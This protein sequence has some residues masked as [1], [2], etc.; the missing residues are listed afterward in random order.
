MSHADTPRP[1]SSAQHD[2]P[3][4]TPAQPLH[5]STFPSLKVQDKHLARQAIVYVCQSTPQQVLQH[6][7][8][9]Q[10]Q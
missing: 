7:E 6:R 1:D 5:G 10:R 4:P 3:A 9:T 8:S 2:R